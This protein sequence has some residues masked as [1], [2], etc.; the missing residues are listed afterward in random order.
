MDRIKLLARKEKWME[1]TM[2][3]ISM[4]RVKICGDGV[5]AKPNVKNAVSNSIMFHIFSDDKEMT[6]DDRKY[7][8]I[9][10]K[11]Q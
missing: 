7:A 11:S 10:Y 4:S 3:E 2:R 1:T 5:K 9:L 8:K 6:A